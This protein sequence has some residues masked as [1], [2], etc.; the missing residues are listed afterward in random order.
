MWTGGIV[1]LPVPPAG[2]KRAYVAGQSVRIVT[3]PFAGLAGIH[4]GMSAGEREVVLISMLGAAR[5]VAIAADL[6]AP[7]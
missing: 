6:I 2:R 3:G 4:L 5:K 7:R 1:R